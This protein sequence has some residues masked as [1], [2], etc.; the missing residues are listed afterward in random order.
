M[1]VVKYP[2]VTVTPRTGETV[3]H[4]LLR[5]CGPIAAREAENGSVEHANAVTKTQVATC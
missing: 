2:Q 1:T 5:V 4:Q 3:N